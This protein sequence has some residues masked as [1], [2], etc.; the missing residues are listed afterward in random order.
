[1]TVP[2]LGSGVLEQAAAAKPELNKL[3]DNKTVQSDAEDSSPKDTR[4]GRIVFM[5]FIF[6]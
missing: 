3:A 4:I 5:D 2:W 1:V 6:L